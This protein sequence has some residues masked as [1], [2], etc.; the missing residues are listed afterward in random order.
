MVPLLPSRV[1]GILD[2]VVG[3]VLIFLPRLFGFQTGGYEE[4]IPVILGVA[5][6]AYSLITRYEWGLFKVLPFKLHLTLDFLSGVLLASSPWLF[7][8]ADRIWLPHLVFGLFEIAAAAI[9]IPQP[10]LA[11]P[12]SRRA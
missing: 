6:L 9:T 11:S 8:F 4:K 10:E 2:Y 7:G 1:H 3:L 12:S 5:A